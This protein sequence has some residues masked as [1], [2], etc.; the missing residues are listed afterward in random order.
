MAR[1]AASRRPAHRTLMRAG[2]TL[3]AAGAALGAGGAATAGAQPLPV[4]E[5]AAGLLV[6]LGELDP[7]A[8]GAA[9]TQALP[10]ATGPLKN[11]QL[12]PLANTGVD[13]LDNAVGTQVA[14]FA[15]VSTAAATGPVAQGGTLKDLPLVGQVTGLIPG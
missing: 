13:P 8:A 4:S 11:L 9:V 10:Y 6:P 2:L 15:P 14:D 3:A 12:D 1:H 7:Q 5:A